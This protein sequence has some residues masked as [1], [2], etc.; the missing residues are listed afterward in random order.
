MHRRGRMMCLIVPMVM[1]VCVIAAPGADEIA[2]RAYDLD[3]G[4]DIK[5]I[6]TMKIVRA[7]R[8]VKKREL[9]FFRKD[10][11]KDTRA[12]VRFQSPADVKDTAFLTWNYRDKESDQWIYLPALKKTNRIAASGKDKSFMK[13]DFTYEELSKRSLSRDSFTLVRE[14]KLD[15]QDCFVL[16]ARSRDSAE[17]I[18][19]RVYWVRSD[20]FVIV[21]ID[22]HTASGDAVKRFTVIAV[23]KIGSI[24]TVMSC[25][26]DDLKKGTHTIL[27][28]SQVTYNSGLPDRF[29][30]SDSMG[31]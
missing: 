19:R 1:A 2:A 27:E 30:R 20:N 25:R 17:V 3:D 24:W 15:G 16:E 14:E 11:G 12:L 10:F 6:M 29:F 8:S 26:M 13:S 23:E 21:R 4:T 9:L 18:S 7:D 28:L 5:A 22:S 31:N